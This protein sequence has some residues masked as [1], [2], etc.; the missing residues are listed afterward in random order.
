MLCQYEY[1]LTPRKAMELIWS[2][3]L[4]THDAPGHNIPLDLH[5]EHLNHVAKDA[6]RGLHANKTEAVIT[7]VRKLFVWG[8]VI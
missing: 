5:Q 1:H 8:G 7:K 2:R 4:S 3:F 6:I